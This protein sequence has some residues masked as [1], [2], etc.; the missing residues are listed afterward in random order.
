MKR[1]TKEAQDGCVQWGK[2]KSLELLR[3]LDEYYIGPTKAFLAHSSKPTIA[4]MFG[5][6]LVQQGDLIS[7][8]HQQPNATQRNT[9]AAPS[10]PFSLASAHLLSA[11][12]LVPAWCDQTHTAT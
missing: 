8:T 3:S 10:H 12:K 2:R 9:S 5:A 6:C 11:R 4:D 1:E 7:V